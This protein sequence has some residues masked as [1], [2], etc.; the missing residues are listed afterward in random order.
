MFDPPQQPAP[1][2]VDH[3]EPVV[4]ESAPP[5]SGI[6]HTLTT[7]GGIHFIMTDELA[8]TEA[9]AEAEAVGQADNSEWVDVQAAAEAEQPAEVEIIETVVEAQINGHTV[10]EES[11]T[12]TTTTEEVSFSILHVVWISC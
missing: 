11:V 12:V 8:E 1:V 9:E 10:V 2:E 5:V 7:P 6:S 4:E 3:E